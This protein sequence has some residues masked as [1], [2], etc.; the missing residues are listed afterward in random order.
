M[1]LLLMLMMRPM[2]A[3]VQHAAGL[4]QEGARP[5]PCGRQSVPRPAPLPGWVGLECVGELRRSTPGVCF[6]LRGHR[7][8]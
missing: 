6:M 7:P 4:H 5:P 8:K 3:Q 1:M 2:M